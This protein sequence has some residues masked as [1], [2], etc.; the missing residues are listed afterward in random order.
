VAVYERGET[1][2][3]LDE[4]I[5]RLKMVQKRQGTENNVSPWLTQA[6]VVSASTSSNEIFRELNSLKR[7]LEHKRLLRAKAKARIKRVKLSTEMH[8]S[9]KVEHEQE[10]SSPVDSRTLKVHRLVERKA[11]I[12]TSEEVYNIFYKMQIRF[13]V[14][15]IPLANIL[16][17]FEDAAVGDAVPL[18]KVIEMLGR[19]PFELK[20]PN[21]ISL[22]ARY[23][24]EDNT[25]S[26]K[27]D[28]DLLMTAPLLHV[29]S[30]LRHV[31][32]NYKLIPE[33]HLDTIR[34]RLR[35]SFSFSLPKVVDCFSQHT[36]RNNG[37]GVTNV[38][39]LVEIVKES[40][41]VL[42]PEDMDYIIM[43]LYTKTR[44]LEKLQVFA[45]LDHLELPYQIA[46]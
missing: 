22:A 5:R 27:A 46:K 32:G 9:D 18:T 31:L 40:G 3:K 17:Y 23:L 4:E 33:E 21:E 2:K 28:S 38:R 43:H 10:V 26:D 45:I 30:I 44:D 42:E 1:L 36:L 13:R 15:R 34:T 24:I 7:E 11:K 12:V 41:A 6:K 39:R 25:K 8:D 20:K 14:L 29:L 19:R 35:A 16:K 37:D